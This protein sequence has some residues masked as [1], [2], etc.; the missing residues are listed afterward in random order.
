MKTEVKKNFDGNKKVKTEKMEKTKES[1]WSE[2][3]FEGLKN[4][5]ID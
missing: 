4:V 1:T 5:K 2:S 3:T